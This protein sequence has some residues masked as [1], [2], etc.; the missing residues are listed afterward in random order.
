M[1][2]LLVLLLGT[3]A[4]AIPQPVDDGPIPAIYPKM[5]AHCHGS[6]AQS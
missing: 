1:D 6:K 3:M 4:D 2:H 5:W